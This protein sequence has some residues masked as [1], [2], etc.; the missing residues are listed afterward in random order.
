MAILEGKNG[1]CDFNRV[2]V[3]GHLQAA[4]KKNGAFEFGWGDGPPTIKSTMEN[5]YFLFNRD[6]LV[7]QQGWRESILSG[8][9][10]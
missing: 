6:C 4:S 5:M 9:K 7:S 3:G 10:Y 2:K 1:F 8:L